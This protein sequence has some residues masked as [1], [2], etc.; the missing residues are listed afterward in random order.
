MLG[1]TCFGFNFAECCESDRIDIKK[2]WG[3]GGVGERGGVREIGKSGASDVRVPDL[4][5]HR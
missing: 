5:L 2:V 3:T 1:L 4:R